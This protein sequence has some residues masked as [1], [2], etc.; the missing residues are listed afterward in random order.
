MP[1]IAA[2]RLS[3]IT[4]VPERLRSANMRSGVIGSLARD[5]MIPKASSSSTAAAKDPMVRR[6][7]HPSSAARMK[8]YTRD[9]MPAVEVT[10]PA[11]SK[12]AECRSDS[13][14]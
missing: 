14:M 1:N 6:S 12:R 9:A 3:M 13:L 10:A 7:F 4:Y 2:A 5:S 11:M 8:P